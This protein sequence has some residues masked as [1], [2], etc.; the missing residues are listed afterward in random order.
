M[1]NHLN[2]IRPI[3]G[4]NDLCFLFGREKLI[5]NLESFKFEKLK[6]ESPHL[7]WKELMDVGILPMQYSITKNFATSARTFQLQFSQKLISLK[8]DH[9]QSEKL[10]RMELSYGW[11]KSFP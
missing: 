3:F 11:G 4:F 8:I 2:V 1:F 5:E 9:L 6:I 10:L 7:S